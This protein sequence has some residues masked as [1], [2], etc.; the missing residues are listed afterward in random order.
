MS[1]SEHWNTPREIKRA[2]PES[3]EA[4]CAAGPVIYTENE[5]KYIDD[6]E[7]HIAV[8][9]RTGKGKSQ[10]CSLPFIREVLDKGESLVMLDP[11]GE[12]YRCSSGVIPDNY[13]K[14]C[15]DFR[16]P[17]QSPDSWNPL[18]VPYRLFHSENPDDRDIACSMVSEFWTG[19]YPRD[20][21][22]DP[23]WPD[24]A[25]QYAKGLTY[26]LFE[27]AK[28]EYVNLDSISAM[29][30]KS[31]QRY[32]GISNLVKE[33]H[34]ML[35]SDS[36][37]KRNLAPYVSAPNETRGSMHTTA[38]SGLEVFSRSRG[39][40]EML[41]NNSFDIQSIDV[42]RPLVLF[43]ITPDETNVY[44]SLAGLLISQVTQHL[45]RASQEM[46]GPL[47]IRVNI[48]LEELG[49]VGKCIPTL[50]NLMVAGRSRNLRIML[51]LQSF[52][53][54]TQVYGNAQAE[55]IESSIG[56]IIG[57][58]TN[59]WETLSEWA[60]RCGEKYVKPN[61]QNG[62]VVKEQLITASQL[63]AMPH[64][65]ALIMVD[66]QYKFIAQLPFYYQSYKPAENPM[67][68]ALPFKETYGHMAIDFEK[69][70]KGMKMDAERK[71]MQTDNSEGREMAFNLFM[72]HP[73]K[74]DPRD[75]ASID[76]IIARLDKK[77]EAL[78]KEE[79]EKNS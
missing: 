69:M 51:I 31:E 64:G 24:S 36:L 35:P 50:P 72:P 9:G 41:G 48:V 66:S 68:K 14:F 12:G 28:E 32:A 65:T 75:K 34:N 16:V 7:S 52:S 27:L 46:E 61:G 5:K 54:L 62:P 71:R 21:A 30:E 63:A 44:D 17:R 42:N 23:F 37:A 26:G 55:T 18:T 73:P 57:F 22:D 2:F 79:E 29:M 74:V 59:N 40:M 38:A 77:I 60:R 47:P 1:R 15:L 6:S 25:A 70:V 39:L 53:Q 58:S 56:L 76:E 11:K 45:I 78:A 33:F 4:G 43:V 3:T 8:I 67:T 10:C 19:V 49:S 20:E 13:Q